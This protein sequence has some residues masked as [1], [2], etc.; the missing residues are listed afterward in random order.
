[1]ESRIAR[2]CSS[3]WI[4]VWQIDR[5]KVGE[6]YLRLLIILS[7]GYHWFQKLWQVTSKVDSK[8]GSPSR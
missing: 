4:S 5:V 8:S 6:E 7:A 3:R 2:E 1:M